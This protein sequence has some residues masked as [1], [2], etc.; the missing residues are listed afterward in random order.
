M[1]LIEEF[2]QRLYNQNQQFNKNIPSIISAHAFIDDLTYFLFPIRS[3]REYSLSQTKQRLNELRMDFQKLIIPLESRL[4]YSVD[5]ITC[6]FFD[7]IPGIYEN[8]LK[9]A[10]AFKDFD[11]AS[12]SVE[13]II[14]Y[15]PGFYSIMVY[16]LSHELYKLGIPYLCRMISEYAHSKTGIDIHPGAKIGEQFLIDHGTGIVIGE[17]CII[18]KNVKIYQGVTLGALMVNKGMASKKRHPTIEDNV[19][20]YAGS[21]ILGGDTI[22]GRDTVIGGNTWITKSIPPN[23][24]VYHESKSVIRDGKKIEGEEP[25]NFVI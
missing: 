11:P 21:T 3:N 15:Y 2:S 16:R 14:V 12:K 8:L 7:S 24:V 18:G 17:T 5:E 4:H 22:I 13:G 6:R 25:I 20:I 9:D 19:V 1:N 23:S 10:Q